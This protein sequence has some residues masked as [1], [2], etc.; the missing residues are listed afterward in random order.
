MTLEVEKDSLNIKQITAKK[1]ELV[2]VEGECIVPDIK[3]DLINIISTSGILNVYK[4]EV[5]NSKVRIDGAI[6]VYV[7]YNG[8][9]G[10]KDSIRSINHILDFSQIIAIENANSEMNEVGNL[11]IE[12]IEARIVNER[13]IS[14]KVT[15]RINIK[16]N[17][18]LNIEYINNVKI[19]DLQKKE[20]KIKINSVFGV[21]YTKTNISEN[22]SIDNA[23]NITEILQVFNSIVNIDTKISYNKILIKADVIVK[24]LYS[25]EDGKINT[26][27][28]T[29]PIMGFIDMKGISDE[30]IIKSNLEIKNAVIKPNGT[31]D[32][33]I[34]VDM[35]ID[36]GIIAYDSKEMITID[37]M[38]SPSK[39]I[40]Y[41]QKEVNLI[42]DCQSHSGILNFNQTLLND[43]GNEKI[44]DVETQVIANEIK[45]LNNAI[46]ISGSIKFIFIHSINKMNGLSCKRIELPFEYKLVCEGIKEGD[47]AELKYEIKN[48]SFNIISDKEIEIKIDILFIAETI[49]NTKI[50]VVDNVYE[51]ENDERSNYNIV[52]YYTKNDDSLWKIAK[53]FCSTTEIIKKDNKLENETI[54]PGMQLFI[55]RFVH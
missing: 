31:Q 5:L 49:N 14:I 2:T 11:S 51:E 28:E 37:D 32:H 12:K 1:S 13:K 38:Y 54:K 48:D 36:M 41:S 55:S 53:E 44:Y 27:K 47:R 39:I 52:I 40:N 21:G 24:L 35:E 18:D 19:N 6:S 9:D 25:T 8:N 22:I 34:S 4:K 50:K 7:M 42:N 45:V 10:E 33:S 30:N 17:S 20:K 29:F 26:T 43:I 3:P 23:N 46:Q 16:L 15:L